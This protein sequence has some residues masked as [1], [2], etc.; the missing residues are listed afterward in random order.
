LEYLVP[1]VNSIVL[2]HTTPG[3][4][5]ILIINNGDKGSIPDIHHDNVRVI[6]SGKNLGWEGGLKLGLE[7]SKNP[8][9]VFMN[10]DTF[11]PASSRFWLLQM[12]RHFKDAKVAAVGPSSNCVMGLQ[13]AFIHSQRTTVYPVNFLIG[14]CMMVRRSALEEVGGID[15]AMPYH[16]DDLDLSTR[17]RKAGYGMICDKDIFIYHHGFKTGQR[18]FG[19][20][21]NSVEMMEKTNTWLIKKHGLKEFWT[22]INQ[23]SPSISDSL[24]RG[25]DLEGDLIRQ[26]IG[27][28]SILEVGCGGNKT[29]PHSTGVDIIAE[30][31]LIPDLVATKSVADVQADISKTL[32]FPQESYD[33]I[34]ARHI[35]EHVVDTVDVV[36]DWYRVLR[37]NGKL[38]VAV[39]NEDICRSIPMDFQHVRAFNPQSLKNQMESLGFKTIA[40]EDPKNQISM[41]GI[42][43][44]NGVH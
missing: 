22:T 3:L 35:L 16:G 2:H 11:I 36:R 39:P 19:S 37:H 10:D 20:A 5:E 30:G 15:D 12:L 31:E 32:P 43:S 34:V 40:I 1:C 14:F 18:E 28:G 8:F 6:E 42:F 7:K 29:V 9:V 21:W 24:P 25:V 33:V 23:T 13:N 26:Y 27:E 38:I 17:F 44:K 41:V 4:Y